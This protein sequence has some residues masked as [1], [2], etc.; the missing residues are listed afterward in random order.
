M[1]YWNDAGTVEQVSQILKKDQI[2][3]ASGD[4][5]LGL[6]GNITATAFEKLNDIKQRTGKPYLLVIGSVDK[7]PLFIDQELTNQLQTLIHTCWPGPV[8][9]IFKARKDLPSWL[10]SPDGTIA[11][12]VPDHE[13]LLEL[14]KGFDALFSTSANSHG[15]PIPEEVTSV[16]RDIVQKVD[17]VVIERGQLVYTQSPSTILN[18]ATGSIEVVRMGAMPSDILRDLLG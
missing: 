11:L 3:L 6:W 18:C 8:T 13:G 10:I 12:R 7:L 2:L 4:T 9:L 17:A 5:V 14:L 16:D 15:K 1:I